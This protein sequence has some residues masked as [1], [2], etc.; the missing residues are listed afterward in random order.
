MNPA[1]ALTRSFEALGLRGAPTLLTYLSKTVLSRQVATV[2]LTGGQPISF[3]AYDP[4]WARHLYAG[5]SY[6]PDVEAIFRRLAGG[7]VLI[8]CGANIGY[9]SV[10]ATELGFSDAIAIEANDELIPLLK[11]NYQGR[12]IHAAVHSRSGE[13][14]HFQGAGATGRVGESGATVRS[15]ALADLEVGTPAVIKL[16]VEGAEIAAIEGA[17]GMDA[18]FVYEDWPKSGMP[19]T[20]HLLENGYSVSGFD[21]SPIRTHAEAFA[22]N[23]R[24]TRRYGPSNFVA[25]CG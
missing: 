17:A 18:I 25:T 19:V 12:V 14:L 20:R 6:E 2:T 11:R 8:D 5:V 23:E 22:F 24:T 7:R 9:W 1:A 3:P 21:M 10:R 15:I 4:Y 13:E 16:D